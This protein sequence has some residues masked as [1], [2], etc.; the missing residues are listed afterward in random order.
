M[1]TPPQ[2]RFRTFWRSL[3][4]RIALAYLLSLLLLCGAANWFTLMR[5]N[6][7][8]HELEQRLNL[9]LADNLSMTMTPALR[10]GANSADAR[11]TAEHILAINPSLSLYV[12][13]SDG[14]V[15]ASYGDRNCG[16]GASVP[17]APLRSLLQQHPMLPVYAPSPCS[18]RPT[19]F[20][21]TEVIYNNHRPGYLYAVL[22]GEPYASLSAML[23]T[24]YVIR[25]LLLAGGLALLLAL[26]VGLAWFAFLTRRFRTLTRVVE[27]FAGADYS[28]RVPSSRDDEIGRLGSAFNNMAAMI[29]AQLAALRE[30]D[31]QRR[32]LVADVSHDFRT[33]LT[34]LRGHAEQL[35]EQI[36]GGNGADRSQQHDRLQAILDNADRL[37]HLAG[38]LALLARLDAYEQ[39]LRI[40]PFSMAELIQDIAVKFRPEAERLGIQLDCRCDPQTPRVAADIALID[41]LL[42][43]LI[44]NALHASSVGG[45]IT[46][47]AEPQP[48][49]VEISV[50]DDGHGIPADELTLV[51]QRFYRVRRDRNSGREGS[52]LGL[53]IVREIL[54]RH[55]GRLQLDSQVGRGTRACFTLKTAGPSHA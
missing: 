11:Q 5:A 19:V 31:R 33:P 21:V 38:Q 6:D 39:A 53:S 4:A 18:G 34:S 13:D 14:H 48:D 20:S 35:L 41:R 16:R 36:D 42:S 50:S 55:G 10:H 37:T 30:T 52:G 45:R 54:E 12:L 29:E 49:G 15:V 9:R 24:S 8:S 28:A 44:D 47:A 7:F 43:N 23:R 17:V 51:T 32:Q 26:A 1:K 46:M 22:N 27:R 25:G 3:Y 2:S 40:E